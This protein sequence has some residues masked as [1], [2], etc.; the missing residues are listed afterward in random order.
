MKFRSF[1]VSA[2]AVLCLGAW[3]G[4]AVAEPIKVGMALDMSGPFSANGAEAKD[5]FNLAIK[6]LGNKLGGFPAEFL[7]TDMTGNP[8]QARQLV[9]RWIQRDQIDFFTGPISSNVALAVAPALIAAKVPYL[10]NNAGPTPLAGEKCSPYYLGTAFENQMLHEPGGVVANEQGFKRVVVIAPNYP[11]GKDAIAGFK[12]RY[13]G[14]IVGEVYTKVGQIDYSAEIAQLRAD[15]PQG[16]YFLLPGAMGINFIKQFVAAG[17]SKDIKMVTAAPSADEDMVAA[18]GDPML[19]VFNASPY[20][21]ELDTP[22]NKKF[23]AE[24]RK[25]YGRNPTFYAAHA[26]DVI[27]NIDAAVRALG[28]KLDD[29][30]AVAK[31][32]R[33]VKFDSVRSNFSYNTNNHPIMDFYTRQIV[34]GADGKLTNKSQGLLLEKYQ[35]S[36]AGECKAI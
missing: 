20:I 28:G 18:V 8:D 3:G 5:A 35:D 7:Q 34:R 30:A 12:R 6:M 36:F 25:A 21:Y 13:K 33:T 32:L 14:E 23:V 16:V 19:G 27:M 4:A 17:L 15:K 2:A 29:K 11:A 1:V 22:A 24:F 9:N 26:Y 31:T 10:S